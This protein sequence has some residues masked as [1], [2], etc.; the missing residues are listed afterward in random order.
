MSGGFVSRLAEL[1]SSAASLLTIESLSAAIEA[2]IQSLKG[3]YGE[4]RAFSDALQYVNF[5][6]GLATSKATKNATG[7][8]VAEWDTT[9]RC[10]KLSVGTAIGTAEIRANTPGTYR[11]DDISGLEV[12]WFNGP[13]Q[14][15]NLFIEI[16]VFADHGL[17]SFFRFNDGRVYIVTVH[18][19]GED[20]FEVTNEV[21]GF[22][23]TVGW[24]TLALR[25][26]GEGGWWSEIRIDGVVI[27]GGFAA[28]GPIVSAAWHDTRIGAR[29]RSTG[30]TS[31]GGSVCVR[32]FSFTT[33]KVPP[34]SVA[35][36]TRDPVS[37]A[38]SL[39]G[40]FGLAPATSVNGVDCFQPAW[41]IGLSLATE[42]TGG[43]V[44]Y[45]YE[46]APSAPDP[47]NGTGSWDP[48]PGTTLEA[49]TTPSILPADLVLTGAQLRGIA[50][51]SNNLDLT[52]IYGPGRLALYV[53]PFVPAKSSR[54]VIAAKRANGPA[55][56]TTGVLTTGAQYTT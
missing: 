11:T 7:S 17:E 51:L 29:V 33:N 10:A 23:F 47:F 16:G 28:P 50:T 48:V 34:I 18:P 35:T 38:T 55:A 27:F 12:T 20:G 6:Q 37:V 44:L 3:P 24:H 9:Y 41:P 13:E 42:A 54:L 15:A 39:V 8:G 5:A 53:P 45:A 30:V 31:A 46:V 56:L 36:I 43:M 22:N 21:A 2:A 32:G 19:G 1:A 14:D 49:N 4:L 40:L 25:T 26:A 52:S